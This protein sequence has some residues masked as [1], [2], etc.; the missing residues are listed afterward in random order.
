MALMFFEWQTSMCQ[1]SIKK[2]LRLRPVRF[3]TS[4]FSI[5]FLIDFYVLTSMRRL[6]VVDF[7]VLDF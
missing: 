3:H 4:T 1:T 6:L 7:Y 2:I 5:C